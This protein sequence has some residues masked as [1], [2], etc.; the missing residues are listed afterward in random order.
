MSAPL[1]RKV[2]QCASTID[3]VVCDYAAGYVTHLSMVL[4]DAVN[5]A[6]IDIPAESEFIASL[7]VDAGADRTAVTTVYS[8]I[9][10]ELGKVRSDSIAALAQAGGEKA[11]SARRRIDQSALMSAAASSQRGLLTSNLF[12]STDLNAVAGRK[13]DSKVD[14]KKLEKAEKKIASK[15]AKRDAQASALS[16]EYEASKLID[17]Q[18]AEDYD[19]FFLTINPLNA[20]FS[21]SGKSKDIKIENFDLYVGA[22]RRI[23]SDTML[24][25]A[26]GRRYGLI[27][28]NGIGKSTLLRALSRRELPVP[29]HITILHVEQEITGDGTL[30]LQSVLDADVWR[31]HLLKEQAQFQN[32]IQEIETNRASLLADDP[33]LDDASPVIR[34]LDDERVEIETS[35]E[36]IYTKL[37]EI[38]SDKAESRAASILF[39]LG[40]SKDAQQQ[41]TNSFSGG[42]RMRL[43]LARALFCKP[44]LLLLD[45]PSNMLDVPSITYLSHY[46]QSYPS[47]VLVVSHD[48][49]FLNEVATDIIY[50]HNERL[51]YYR[52]ANFDSFYATKEERYKN[53]VRE[54]ESQMAYRKHLQTFIDKF[55]YNA[56]KSSEAQSRIKKL[57]KLP[58]LEAP[59]EDKAI[60]F[61]FPV[62]EKLSPPIIQ[63]QGVTFGYT[64]GKLLLSNVDLDVQM[65]S[66][67]A[68]V[69]ANGCGKTTLLKLLTEQIQPLDGVISRNPRLRIGYFAQHH[70]DG[71]DL[72]MSAVAWMAH[73]Q[74][75]KGEEEY[76]R[77]L[78]SFGIT[79]SLSLQK[80]QLLSGGQKSRVA[81]ACLCLSNP[82]VLILDEPSNHLDTAGLDA[83]SAALK[84]FKG[85][86][87]MVS[88]D[89]A[90]IDQVCNQIWVSEEGSVRKFPGNIQ[91]YKKYIL[92]QASANGVVAQ[93]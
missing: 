45:E 46:L 82:H 59:E 93:H 39:G 65:D 91:A 5:S 88:H 87:L 53:A 69:G 14:K 8:D 24:T 36:E 25:L 67:I 35:L 34:T 90:V 16:V 63:L 61:T 71:M 18:S 32:K 43:A 72:N 2:R 38:E 49:S 3:P 31:K 48:R 75:G 55:R 37:V 73:L 52:G 4:E 22:G 29:Q 54:Y 33:E 1:T 30:A 57:E 76:R 12:G 23:L 84:N 19:D 51:D 85:G 77:H 42:W 58:L 26:H 41:P 17:E 15:K 86:I 20:G 92:E 89:V 6:N 50:Q 56:A 40:F 81:F 11:D 68:L 27:G 83:L 70:V 10:T 9:I 7:L 47:T 80:M 62:P 13:I 28:Q 74:P 79:G 78:G 60:S 64:P 44:D 66:R 21:A